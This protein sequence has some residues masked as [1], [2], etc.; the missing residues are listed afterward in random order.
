[1][2]KAMTIFSVIVAMAL[3]TA[4]T[5]CAQSKL[6]VKGKVADVNGEPLIG[7]TVIEQGTV[8]GVMTDADGKYSINVA[9]SATLL[10]DY[11]GYK[12]V[13]MPVSGKTLVD[14]VMEEDKTQLDEAVV[15]G[16][17]T[18]KRSDL[19]GSVSSVSSKNIENF[20]TGNV[21]DALGGQVAGVN[22]TTTDGTPGSGFNII[23][24]GVSTVNGDSSPLYIVDGFEVENINHIAN[25]DIASIEI[26]KDASASAIYGARA[27]NGVVLVTT[28]SG[29]ESRAVVS[30]SGSASYRTLSKRLDVLDPY[31][32][33]VLQVERH[34]DNAQKYY[35]GGVD[36]YDQ[37]YKYQ[38]A[39]DY[40]NRKG[41]NWQDEAFQDTWSQNHDVSISGGSKTTKYAVSFSH[42]DEDGIFINSGYIKDAARAKLNQKLRD[43]LELD[44]NVS[45]TKQKKYGLGTGG[46]VLRNIL[47]YR[48]TGGLNVTD[49]VLLN[50]S[51]DP[52]I[53]NSYN[54]HYN[55]LTATKEAELKTITNTWVA[56][57]SLTFKITND[58]R[59]KTSGSYNQTFVR[60]DYF[61]YEDSEQAAR[62]GGPYG[63][64]TMTWRNNWS[65]NNVLTYNKAIDKK[66]KI[67][68]MLGQ[69]YQMSGSEYLRGQAKQFAIED[70]GVDKLNAGDLASLVETSRSDKKRLSFFSRAFYNYDGRYLF[71]A[72][73]RA[74]ASSVFAKQ[75]RWG[76]FP[77]FAG[78]WTV[79]NEP[80]MSDAKS[81]LDNLKLRV[82]Y[83]TVGNDRISSYMTS[84][85]YTV[86]KYGLGAA[87]TGALQLNQ[88]SNSN[89]KW[90][91]ST[92]MNI[93]ID[94]S[95]FKGRAGL[96]IDAFQKDTKDLLLQQNLAFVSG[97]ESQW[98]NIGKIRNRGLEISLNT[99]NINKKNF[100]WSTDF[101]ISFIQNELVSLLDG[102]SYMQA[103][104][105]FD[106]NN[107][108]YDYI[109]I[110][111]QPLG[112]MYGFEYDGVYQYSDFVIDPDGN[113]KVKEGVVDNTAHVGVA[114]TPGY[115]KYKDQ[116]TIDTDGDGIPD[117]GDGKIT[118]ADRTV[119][120]NGYAD[121]YGGMTNTF[122]I[123]GFD[124]SVVLQ[125][126][127]GN[128]VYNVTRYMA[129][130]TKENGLNMRTEVLDRWS[131]YNA[132][133]AVPAV[134]GMTDH[135]IYS[136]FIEDGSYLRFKNVTLGYSFP[137]KWMSKI[138]VSKLRLYLS[139]N[140]LYCL[141]RYSGYDPEVNWK[142]SPIMPGVDYGSYPKNTAYTM[143]LEITF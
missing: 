66:H 106:S 4:Q 41:I 116:P 130:K 21:L 143:G 121:W 91:G 78:A 39:E 73:F 3:I 88:L 115:V 24:R 125:F 131:P 57:G 46:W 38:S 16:Y 44:L 23:V 45:Y 64:S 108:N 87:Q 75:N 100:S 25:Q 112:N 92:T 82:G 140:N 93:G 124:L 14:A 85:I 35:R 12:Q 2:R 19:T 110:V 72:T 134:L 15:V 109:A 31:E 102:T 80:W 99:V 136:R 94:F 74:D 96:T 53:D 137:S 55:P 135:D 37:P 61:Y 54:N 29:R 52:D 71:T 129:T 62:S 97:W 49:D 103:R 65:I 84:D 63:Q 81:W 133:N 1:M 77:S 127:Y 86:V 122:H 36:K 17:G 33:V 69:E 126:S 117:K 132:S 48:P 59:L 107:K 7:V 119:I 27:A 28:K 141:T 68:A 90:E 105:G 13:L 101:N 6:T 79:S 95:I 8:N 40:K 104:T 5:V 114:P 11:M 89:L 67:T 98:Q 20:K 111:G 139:A 10:F 128:D 123:Y 51:S 56:N 83:G 42:F 47:A 58:L 43:W 9:K 18:M 70:L 113:M 60:D 142:N 26:L 138:K 76:F 34:S 32:F 118:S 30:Y 50:S 120:G 22:I